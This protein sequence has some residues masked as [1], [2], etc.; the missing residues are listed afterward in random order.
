MRKKSDARRKMMLT[1]AA[2]A[3]QHHGFERTSMD[4]IA[5]L[6]GCS[7]VTLYAYFESKEQL[8]Y[9]AI[10]RATDAQ[11]DELYAI[12]QDTTSPIDQVLLRFGELFVSLICS[13]RVR[14]LRVLVM[15][16]SAHGAADLADRCYEAGPKLGQRV[17]IDFLSK[18]RQRGDLRISNLEVAGLQLRALLEAEWLDSLFY[19]E[20]VRAT[21]RRIHESSKRAVEAFLCI[22]TN[23]VETTEALPK[24]A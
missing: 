6:S 15:T 10:A 21:K 4:G 11:F 8:F 14:S 13:H 5:E 18:A 22:Y 19:G 20:R 1:K 9:E 12:L 2:E 23:R 16:A 7:K 17:C 24:D 3:F